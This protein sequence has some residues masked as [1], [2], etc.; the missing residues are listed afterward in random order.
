MFRFVSD[1]IAAR[2]L[3]GMGVL[4]ARVG[5]GHPE[6]S[7]RAAS[8]RLEF[9]GETAFDRASEAADYLETIVAK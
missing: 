9:Y 2:K 7:R 1:I 8:V 6:P 4:L 3:R 5:E